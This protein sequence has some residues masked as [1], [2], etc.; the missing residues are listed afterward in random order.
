MVNRKIKTGVFNDVINPIKSLKFRY[1]NFID[2]TYKIWSSR[3]IVL[4]N[5]KV[6]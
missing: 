2:E 4:V 3:K 6:N 5:S 1:L